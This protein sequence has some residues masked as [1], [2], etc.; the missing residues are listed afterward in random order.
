MRLRFAFPAWLRREAACIVDGDDIAELTLHARRR[1][2]SRLGDRLRAGN[3]SV[4][5]LLDHLHPEAA[6]ALS[7]AQQHHAEQFEAGAVVVGVENLPTDDDAALSAYRRVA[8]APVFSVNLHDVYDLLHLDE[9][10][11]NTRV[12][13]TLRHLGTPRHL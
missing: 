7:A 2:V 11:V 4:L 1:P 10:L 12:A 13:G 3:R 8:R 5:L 9:V 6:D